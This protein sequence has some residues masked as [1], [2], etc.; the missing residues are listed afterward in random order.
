VVTVNGDQ[1]VD[2]VTASIL[3]EIDGNAFAVAKGT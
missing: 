2:Q 1:S 3:K